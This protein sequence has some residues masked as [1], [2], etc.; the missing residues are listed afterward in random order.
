MKKQKMKLTTKKGIIVFVLLFIALYIIIYIVPTVFD[1]FKQTYIAEYGTLEVKEDVK[2]VF[3]RDEAVYK[4]SSGGAVE[5]TAE[6]GDLLRGGNAVVTAAG[7]VYTAE[8]S[9]VVSYYY[10]GYESKLS[11]ETMGELTKDFM[12]EY[13]KTQ[14][15]VTEMA[16]GTVES[17]QPLFKLIDS[18]QW[19]LVCWMSPEKSEIFKEGREVIVQSKEGKEVSMT[20][21]SI[22]EQGEDVQI[23]LT[24]NRSYGDFDKY[25]IQNC[26]I[27]ASRHSG[28]L[29]KDDS[30][31]EEDGQKGVYVV[32]KFG[33]ENFVPV[34]ILS[35][36]DGK[37][38]VEKNFFHDAEG[39]R[40]ETIQT[41]SEVVKGGKNKADSGKSDD[42]KTDK[43][44]NTDDK[45]SKKQK[46]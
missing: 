8:F 29:L 42:D 32:D 24:C 5:R 4:A 39:N 18:G 35:S 16:S 26:T 17:G 14:S 40:I 44:D 34:H 9:G 12:S 23:I 2:C 46:E 41:Y 30:I 1:I 38:V 43:K 15:G 6:R 28:I 11:S 3:V 37:T 13:E 19:Y 10:D 22:K 20:V 36:Q 27:I 31:V 25:R 33:G 45:K 7:K 21:R